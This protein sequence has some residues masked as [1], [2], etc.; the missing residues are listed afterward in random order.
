[1]TVVLKER[2]DSFNAE[3][4]KE[5]LLTLRGNSPVGELILDAKNLEYISS[6]GLRVLLMLSKKEN[7]LKVVNVS[8]QVYDI[9]EMTGF[10]QFLKIDKVL[11]KQ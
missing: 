2:I 8:N 1:M 3:E 4:V 7:N 9:F 10:T 11:E 5:E 6:A